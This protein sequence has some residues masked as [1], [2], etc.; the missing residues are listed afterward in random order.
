MCLAARWLFSEP[1]WNQP[2]VV[3]AAWI[4]VWSRSQVVQAEVQPRRSSGTSATRPPAAGALGT[5][6]ASTRL[7][8]AGWLSA[9]LACNRMTKRLAGALICGATA[10]LLAASAICEAST[11]RLSDQ[12]TLS[13]LVGISPAVSSHGQ[14]RRHLCFVGGRVE[15]TPAQ[16]GMP[17]QPAEIADPI[18]CSSQRP[19]AASLCVRGE[20]IRIKTPGPARDVSGD[21]A[22]RDRTIPF[23]AVAAGT[24]A[25]GWL[26][27]VRFNHVATRRHP[28]LLSIRI[29]YDGAHAG[30]TMPIRVRG[31]SC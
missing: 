16:G 28:L 27:P 10:A 12:A 15:G 13:R 30:W 6:V 2:L 20:T 17:P 18:P 1:I 29:D 25:T 8:V 9:A 31:M 22:A 23:T 26:A 24:G 21:I 4:V 14:T 3:V 7:V 11:A 19:R 5:R